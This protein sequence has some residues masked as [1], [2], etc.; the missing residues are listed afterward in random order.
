MTTTEQYAAW[1]ANAAPRTDQLRCRA[2]QCVGAQAKPAEPAPVDPGVPEVTGFVFKVQANMDPKHRDRIAFL[3][4]CSGHFERG[5]RLTL[6]RGG[7]Q[8][9]VHNPIFFLAQQRGLAEEAW[10]GDIIGVPNHGQLRVCDALAETTPVRFTGIPNF[11]PEILMR[12]R[13]ADAMRAKHL[14]RAL[15]DL[16]EE[17][18]TQVFRPYVGN[19]WIVGVVGQLQLD[20][21]QTRLAS[22]YDVPIAFE[23]APYVTARWCAADERAELD[24]FLAAKRPSLAEDGDGNPVY[25]AR[26]S[27]DLGRVQEDFPRIRLLAT[28]ERH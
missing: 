27:W 1:A 22:E 24:R 7:K 23:A 3:R 17:G 21:L 6:A 2:Q 12:V 13:L 8:V 19:E 16:A 18:V 25:V 11:A 10:P 15:A 20:V 26:N 14:G 4:L 5:M 28:R 9:T